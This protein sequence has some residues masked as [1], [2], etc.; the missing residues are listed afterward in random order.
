[1]LDLP[2]DVQSYIAD[3]LPA[4]TLR[5]VATA[6]FMHAEPEA[7]IRKKIRLA[8]RRIGLYMVMRYR[9]LSLFSH[10]NEILVSHEYFLFNYQDKPLLLRG[11]CLIYGPV[12]QANRLCR[13]CRQPRA[14]HRYIKMMDMY[15]RVV[16]SLICE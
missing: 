4:A 1:M 8:K 9:T 3:L 10:M 15:R 13:F 2:C 6:G 16:H 5:L 14:K 7:P 11:S 12:D